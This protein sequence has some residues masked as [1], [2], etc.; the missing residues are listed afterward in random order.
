VRAMKR[1]N[2]LN[3]KDPPNGFKDQVINA[4]IIGGYAGFSTLVGLGATGLL[5]DPQTGIIAALISGG[6]AFFSSLVT[7]RKLQKP[8]A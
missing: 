4:A 6:F 1:H 8:E 5:Q 2:I 3:M 7:Q